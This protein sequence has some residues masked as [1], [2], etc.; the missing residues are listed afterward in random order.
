MC[1]QIYSCRQL[2]YISQASYDMGDTCAC[3]TQ[4]SLPDET[5]CNQPDS[6]ITHIPHLLQWLA[7]YKY[8][9]YHLWN[10][11]TF[12]KWCAKMRF[13]LRTALCKNEVYFR[14]SLV[15]LKCHSFPF[16]LAK[17]NL[18]FEIGNYNYYP[19]YQIV[20]KIESLSSRFSIFYDLLSENYSLVH[21]H[22]PRNR[23]QSL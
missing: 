10:G 19:T 7:P 6:W 11:Q 18:H 9:R 3:V 8:A 2:M 5:R 13:M 4:P 15:N 12:Q 23:R 21:G 16:W 22:P 20:K 1:T 17:A 14:C